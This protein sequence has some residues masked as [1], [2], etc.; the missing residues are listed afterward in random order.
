MASPAATST[1]SVPATPVVPAPAPAPD[2][3]AVP[4]V[5][6]APAPTP[7]KGPPQEYV[8][9]SG[10]PAL[11][12]FEKGKEGSH[13]KFWGNF[14]VSASLR[15]M[16]IQQEKGPQDVVSWLVYRP[17]YERRGM[18]SGQDFIAAVQKKADTVGASL[19]WFS[20]PGEL[21]N[22][23]NK[24]KD[25][26]ALPVGDFEYFGHSN[27]ACFMFDYSNEFD[28]MSRSFFHER[29]ISL[30][31]PAAF[32]SDAKA[33]SWGCHTGEEFS[34][35]W[36]QKLGF[37]MTGAIGK[38]DYSNGKIPVLSAADGKWSE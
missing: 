33:K 17:T 22:Y 7:R 31:D 23:L 19:Y 10:G 30:L 38:T 1:S 28:A 15:I 13:D 3:V 8:I 12:F 26:K 34:D 5:P 9:V 27:R 21:F 6:P 18:E 2:A 25:R 16:E 37:T 29:Q 36:K 14:I 11:R 20:E 32:A 4:S 35:I 24:G